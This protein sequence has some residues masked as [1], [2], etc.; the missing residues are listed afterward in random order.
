MNGAQGTGSILDRLDEASSAEDFFALLGVP[1]DPKI[2]NVARLHVL[3]RMGQY[4][5]KEQFAGV[6]EAEVTERCKAMLE[7]AYADFVA[8]SPI[9]Q[10]VFKVLKDAVVEPKKPAAFVPLSALK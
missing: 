6:A 1:Y 10:R 9:E 4:L 8:S 7:R 5:A 3:R 2:L